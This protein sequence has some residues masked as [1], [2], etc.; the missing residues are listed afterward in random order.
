MNYWFIR[1]PYK[2]RGW[3]DALIRGKYI[4]KGIRNNQSRNNILL[5]KLNDEAVFYCSIHN[6]MI[7]GIMKVISNVYQDSTTIDPQWLS[8]D[9]K[10]I[11]TFENPLAYKD[12][13][14]NSILQNSS[15]IRQP[16][17]TVTPLSE[18]EYRMIVMMTGK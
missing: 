9:F 10:P 17:V 13:K 14:E 4:L 11:I 7:Y 18:A 1:S 5:M 15:F 16:R 3:T 8:I 12:L 6:K 2:H